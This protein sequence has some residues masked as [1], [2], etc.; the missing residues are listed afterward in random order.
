MDARRLLALCLLVAIVPVPPVLG[1]PGVG[2]GQEPAG[3]AASGP[4]VVAVGDIHGAY[5]DFARLLQVTGLVDEDLHWVGGDTIFVQ[6]GDFTDRGSGVR[7]VMDLLMR[8]E[9]EAPASGGQVLVALGNHE[10]MNIIGE[11]RDVTPEIMA[12]F[13]DEDAEDTQDDAFKEYEKRVLSSDRRWSQ[14]SRSQKSDVKDDWVAD[15][16]QGYAEYVRAIGPDGLYGQ[17]MRQL[18]FGIVVQG[19]LFQH[20]G[21]T[22]ELT[23][24]T[25]DTIN[26]RVAQEVRAFDA[27]RNLLFE[28]D[29]TTSF[30]NL[31]EII[32]GAAT[33]TDG[34]DWLEDRS[35]HVSDPPA[36]HLDL[37]SVSN[38]RDRYQPLFYLNDWFLNA[39]EGPLWFRGYQRW[40][41]DEGESLVPPLLEALDVRAIV[42]GHTPQIEGARARFDG[43]IFMIDTGMLT[44]RYGGEAMALEIVGDRFTAITLDG[45]RIPMAGGS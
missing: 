32:R 6:T 42:V 11:V 16:P 43:Q 37:G 35:A 28:E 1:S 8:L 31:E 2:N 33:E 18:P 39:A 41:D 9:Q 13:A 21:I 23:G 44:E 7:A 27:Y 19:V 22:P 45:T 20:A 4:R 38:K 26:A 30:S 40:T 3:A 24:W 10:V 14:L 36:L 15:H 25:I 5:D 29:R 34:L 17:W 12:T